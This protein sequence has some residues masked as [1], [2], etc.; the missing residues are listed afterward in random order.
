MRILKINGV[1]ANIDNA[2]AIGIDLQTYDV[3]EPVY[4]KVKISNSFTIP[5]TNLNLE[6]IGR[7]GGP[8]NVSQTI[9]NVITCDYFINN[10]QY[11]FTAKLR[12]QKVKHDI[13]AN[14]EKGRIEIFVFEKADIWDTLKGVQWGDFVSAYFDSLV[15]GG[16]P[17]S[18]AQVAG[19]WSDFITPYTLLAGSNELFIPIYVGNDAE[20]GNNKY[21]S[22]NYLDAGVTP[23]ES[24]SG[25]CTFI[26][27]I[28]EYIEDTY[29][30]DFNTGTVFDGNIWDDVIGSGMYTVI[31]DI[32]PLFD[33]GYYFEIITASGGL[34][35]MT[36]GLYEE[37]RD[38]TLYDLVLAFFHKLN[39][40]IS[41]QEDGSY[42]LR[43]FDDLETLAEV[44]DFSGNIEG[45]PEFIPFVPGYNQ[46]SNIKIASIEEGLADTTSQRVLTSLNKNIDL[47]KELFKINEYVGN[48]TDQGVWDDFVPI[49]S[50]VTSF[51]NFKF[52]VNNGQDTNGCDVRII[53]GGGDISTNVSDMFY[54][55]FYSLAGEYTLLDT[56]LNYPKYYEVKK[57][58]NSLDLLNFE[59]FKLYWIREL[60]GSFFVNKIKGFNPEKS[61]QA[62]EMELLRVSDRTPIIFNPQPS[63][64]F[65]TNK[66][67]TFEP[68]VLVNDTSQATWSVTGE[69]NQTTNTPSFTLTGDDE[70]VTLTIAYF[71]K[72]ITYDIIDE[73]IKG[74]LD[75]DVLT[76]CTSFR[77]ST[78]AE[79]T[80][81]INPINDE[82]ITE[83]RIA[84]TGITTLDLST[85]SKLGGVFAAF[86]CPDLTT[87]INP[88]SSQAFTLYQCNLSKLTGNI[89]VSGL[90]GLGGTF[91]LGGNALLT[92][93]TLPASSNNFDH[94]ALNSTGITGILDLSNLTLSGNL[95]TYSMPITG[96]V[97]PTTGNNFNDIFLLATSVGVIDWT[98][99]TGSVVTIRI[100]GCLLTS[101]EADENIV[102]IDTNINL[103]TTLNIA[104][105]NAVLT[106]GS[107][108]G[109]DGL[110]AKDQL[111]IEGVSVSYN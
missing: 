31:R 81:V 62:T 53:E 78:N 27:S 84:S 83:Y 12:V 107:V 15:I 13:Q 105:N 46:N 29:S 36:N 55:A 49:V 111:V 93:I 109:F 42:K 34:Q 58:L 30:V 56:A 68:I 106:D 85:F 35:Y 51:K 20:G 61:K 45:L 8:Q 33:T 17:D 70:T 24:G 40:I 79:L 18:S 66:N 103:T 110:A 26:K 82:I 97:F 2:T 71:T 101:A 32:F 74:A 28:F 89:D 41:P 5:I 48:V 86:L 64:I 44:V 76:K 4:R 50:T 63:I 6:L 99:L 104:G 98:P 38:K 65:T 94:F 19:S 37:T 43:R 67:G 52:F 22:R 102:S 77:L 47:E 87:I 69:S 3:K 95:Y 21:L 108:T 75:L 60:N 7:I 54:A 73:N 72:I 23:S 80:S 14:K 59:F 100:D 91:N 39:V 11:I 9:Y 92:S 16:L 90:T 1:I 57:W 25:M 96:I 88:I 10:T